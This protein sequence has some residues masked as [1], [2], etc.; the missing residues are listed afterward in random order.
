MS[1][2]RKRGSKVGLFLHR[3]FE[4]AP[5]LNLIIVLCVSCR[6]MCVRV[7]VTLNLIVVLCVSCRVMC[8]RVCVI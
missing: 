8:V 4:N 5:N 3:K 7:C 1:F 6:V 2:L